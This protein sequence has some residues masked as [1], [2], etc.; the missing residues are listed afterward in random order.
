MLALPA[1]LRG[2]K[3]SGNICMTRKYM[4]PREKSSQERG[5]KGG[6]SSVAEKLGGCACVCGVCVC[7][8]SS[9]TDIDVRCKEG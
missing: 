7:R 4:K 8:W 5:Y 6:V 2:I 3:D 9:V 1:C